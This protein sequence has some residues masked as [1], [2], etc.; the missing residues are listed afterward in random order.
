LGDSKKELRVN[1]L[2]SKAIEI[3]QGKMQQGDHQGFKVAWA[4]GQVQG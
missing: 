2:I 1:Y 4:T 3:C